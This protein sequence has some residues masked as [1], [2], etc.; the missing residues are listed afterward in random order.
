MFAHAVPQNG[1]DDKRF[2]V[3]CIVEDVLW[4]GYTKVLVRSD[5]EPAIVKLLKESLAAHKVEGLEHPLPYDSQSNGAI[6]AAVKQVRGRMKT[7]KLCLERWIGKRISPGHPIA[8]WLVAHC[9]AVIR[10]RVRGVD[11]KTP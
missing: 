4:L 1:I 2:A 3:D 7:L 5:N 9:A 11:G 6:E 8:A 10:F